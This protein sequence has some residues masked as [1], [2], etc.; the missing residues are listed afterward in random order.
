M[1]MPALK[2]ETETPVEEERIARLEAHVEHM[3][4]DI[5]DLKVDVRRLDGKIDDMDKRLCGEIRDGDLRVLGKIEEVDKRL[6]GKIEEV[7]KR[8]GGKIDEVDKRLSGKI[9]ALDQKFTAKFDSL[10][11]VMDKGFTAIDKKFAKMNI[12]RVWDRVWFLLT[13]AGIFAVMARGFKWI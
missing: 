6:G 13:A 9:E 5:S 3:R 1:A 7:D 12:S 2:L 8:L 10:K 11:D 4:S